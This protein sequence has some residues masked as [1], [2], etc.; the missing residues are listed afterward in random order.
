MMADQRADASS[1]GVLAFDV[2]GANLKAADGRG[3]VHAESFELWRRGGELPARLRAI[4]A[5]WSPGRIVATMTGEIADCFLDRRAGV[6]GIVDGLRGAAAALDADLGIYLVDGR[7]VSPEVALSRPLDAAAS[8]WHVLG[9]LAAAIAGSDHALLVD[10]GSTT[11]DILFLDR[12]GPCPLAT[13]DAGRM[14]SGELVYT[15]IERTP[16]AAVVRS[17]PLAGCR[18]PIAGELFARTQDVW[19][20]LG[21]IPEDPVSTDTADG[22]P[23]TCEA[24]RIRLAR[25][26]LLEPVS[27]DLDDARNAAERV[28]AAQVRLVAA[29]IRRVLSR[30]RHAPDRVVISGHGGALAERAVRQAGLAVSLVRLDS[31]LGAAVSRAAPAHALALVA[32]GELP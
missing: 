2:G 8:N 29:A 25:Q 31:V 26:T 21:A 22:G 17:V 12:N 24:A 16:V 10:V 32:L 7:I 15:G 5:G 9:R 19:L 3:R 30:W 27:V 6:A 13:D 23:A 20:L 14:A 28:A 18:R 1:G 11:T 4:A